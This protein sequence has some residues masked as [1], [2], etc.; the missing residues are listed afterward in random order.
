MKVRVAASCNGARSPYQVALSDVSA[1]GHVNSAQME[2]NREITVAV[3]YLDL[4]GTLT[5]S[6]HRRFSA[7]YADNR[8]CGGRQH[9]G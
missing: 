7:P 2:I 6:F 3:V 8:P 5:A 1:W 4:S 9:L